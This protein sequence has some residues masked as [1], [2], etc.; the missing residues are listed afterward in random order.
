VTVTYRTAGAWG[1]GKG[2]NLTAAEVDSNFWDHEGRIDTLESTP[3]APNNIADITVSGSQMTITMDDA[4]T[5]GPFTLP[6][7]LWRWRDDWLTA[8]AY[9]VNDLVRDSVSGSVYLVLKGHTSTGS[10]MDPDLLVSGDPAFEAIIDYGALGGGGGASY[11]GYD[12]ISSFET[13]GAY[14]LTAGEANYFFYVD[15]NCTVTVPDDS[16][17]DFPIGTTFAFMNYSGTLTLDNDSANWVEVEDGKTLVAST[18]FGSVVYLQKTEADYWVAWGDL[19]LEF[20]ADANLIKYTGSGTS[21]NLTVADHPHKTF[22]QISEASNVTVIIPLESSQDFPIGYEITVV[23]WLLDANEITF[24]FAGGITVVKKTGT[25][26]KT[27]D[28]G[29]AVTLKKTGSDH[30]TIIGDYV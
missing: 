17:T 16:T 22:W 8:T 24:S 2:S 12:F 23:Q 27:T 21:L 26:P 6:A 11:G 4:S 9:A 28:Y 7:S 1:A 13:A 10:D 3:P 14:T 30:W 20:P 19:A 18:K 5:F 15:V 25:V 29:A